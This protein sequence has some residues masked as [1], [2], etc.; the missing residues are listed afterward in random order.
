MDASLFFFSL[1]FFFFSFW[2]CAEAKGFTVDEAIKQTLR[3]ALYTNTLYRGLREACK[4]LDRREG[5]F[6]VLAKNCDHADYVKVVEG[7]CK[8]YGTHLIR[9]ADKI[10][11]GEWSGLCTYDKEGA[12]HKV[13]MF[14]LLLLLFMFD[15]VDELFSLKRLSVHPAWLFTKTSRRRPIPL[16]PG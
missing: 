1:F 8:E 3:K 7:L 16:L 11:L 2:L 9:V 10:Q 6:C 13:R 4:V 5:L 14:L 15:V 12:A